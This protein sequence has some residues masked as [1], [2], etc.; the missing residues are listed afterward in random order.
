VL[1]CSAQALNRVSNRS[2]VPNP[3]T[4]VS[5]WQFERLLFWKTQVSRRRHAAAMNEGGHD[6]EAFT[7]PMARLVAV[8]SVNSDELPIT[9]TNFP[10]RKLNGIALG[11]TGQD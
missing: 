5:Q 8:E 6:G 3:T 10:P 1:G 4:G 7:N 11:W 2:Q 9:S